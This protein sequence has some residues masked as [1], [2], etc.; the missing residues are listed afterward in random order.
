MLRYSLTVTIGYICVLILLHPLCQIWHVHAC[1]CLRC[2][3]SST[4]GSD[5]LLV[6]ASDSNAGAIHRS[7]SHKGWSSEHIVWVVLQFYNK[8]NWYTA[9]CHCGWCIDEVL[10]LNSNAIKASCN[11]I[12]R[13]V[14]ESAVV[15]TQKFTTSWE[16]N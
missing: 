5:L 1:L 6:S 11:V 10:H 2:T 12:S 4:P 15:L 3:I 13:I 9:H 8:L 7:S 14:Y 16:L